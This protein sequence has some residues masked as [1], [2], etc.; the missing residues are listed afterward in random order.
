MSL[1]VDKMNAAKPQPQ[2]PRPGGKVTSTQLNN[3]KDLDVDY[4]KEEPSFFGSFFASKQKKKGGP[5]LEAV[6]SCVRRLQNTFL[7]R[8]IASSHY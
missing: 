3:N 2:E 1:I 7:I 6:R 5:V 8:T 4:K